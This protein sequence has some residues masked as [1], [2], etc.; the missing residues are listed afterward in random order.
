MEAGVADTAGRQCCLGDLDDDGLL[1]L[2]VT[3]YVVFDFDRPPTGPLKCN[4]KA[5]NT[6]CG[7]QGMISSSDRL[8]RNGGD[9]S[10]VD[11]SE[12]T[13]LATFLPALGVVFADVDDADLDIYVANDS[14]RNLLFENTGSWTF[15]ERAIESGLAYSRGRPQA[16]MGVD[17]ADFDDDGDIDIVVTNF[18]DDVNTL[19]LNDGEGL[20][21]DRTYAAGLGSIV[22]PYLGWSTGFSTTT[23]TA[24]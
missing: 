14:E 15:R 22:R 16:G 2:Y 3:N 10:F 5:T 1:D 11:L 8:Y 13:P 20:F 4:Y 17:A 6:F 24:I 9:N 19:Y 18:S 7:P 23:T 12:K 21:A